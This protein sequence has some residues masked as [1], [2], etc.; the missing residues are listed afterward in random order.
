VAAILSSR[1]EVAARL[2]SV[3]VHP[4]SLDDLYRHL[5]SGAT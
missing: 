1:S 2:R 4:P 5:L 3:E